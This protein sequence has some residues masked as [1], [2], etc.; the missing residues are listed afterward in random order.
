[1]KCKKAIAVFMVAIVMVLCLIVGCTKSNDTVKLSEGT[2]KSDSS[3]KSGSLEE[4]DEPVE[5]SIW[6]P[7]DS[8]YTIND[9]QDK[10][11][12]DL[13]VGF[14]EDKF[15]VKLTFEET[16][17]ATEKLQI[18]ISTNSLT[19]IV[20]GASA[21]DTFMVAPD[22]LFAD[23]LIYSL[24][25]F[26]DSIT[27]YS[28]I[29][30]KY[31]ALKKNVMDDE[32]NILY[33]CQPAIELEIG[34]SGGLMIRKDWLE[35]LNLKDPDTLEEWLNT[36]RAFKTQ[37]ANGNGDPNDEIPF[38]GSRGSLNVFAN[39]I[40]VQESFSME[41]GA[42]GE[43]IFG[44]FEQEMY[45]KRLKF[46][47]TM[48]EEG[49]INSN[50]TSM[51]GKMRDTWMLDDKAGSTLTGLGNMGRW[52]IM[53]SDA[54]H[55][56]FLMW[57]VANPVMEDGNRY[58]D[59]TDITKQMTNE[60][61]FIS[62]N[63]ENPE[64]C[65]ELLNYFYTE[66]GRTL[67]TFGVKDITY[68]NEN[69]FLKFT[70]LI[71]HNPDGLTPDDANIKYVGIPGAISP[72]DIRV[73]AQKSLTT[74][75]QRQAMMFTWTDVFDESMNT[76]LPPALKNKE[77]SDEYSE[78]AGDLKTYM[79]EYIDM[80]VQGQLD[81]DSNYDEF[82][83]SLKGLG[84]ERLLELNQ[85]AVKAWQQRG[86]FEY[87]YVENRANITTWKSLPYINQK[88]IEYVDESIK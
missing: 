43:V 33:F 68:T 35:N 49:L 59:R 44:P 86:G 58:F 74:P 30:E 62:K 66:E 85:K 64:K 18:M 12:R 26:E 37:D 55:E 36:F 9:R 14:L 54:G 71:M 41:G 69:G 57:P 88:G 17:M 75:P 24:N 3:E 84:A 77:D 42:A 63:A 47:N 72:I 80:F 73:H 61:L 25:E 28:K 70:D 50:Y 5:I 56:T 45:K 20:R 15:N 83:E 22:E 32:G 48:Y 19:D 7:N 31:P 53:Q 16:S 38:V 34:F 27:D 79:D 10:I 8:M 65:A 1:M 39:T 6:S 87:K 21:F 51:D 60:A 40:G 29:L 4:S 78:L 46:M 52:N 2:K 81:I 11:S 76:P 13:D 23:N 67:Q 82:V